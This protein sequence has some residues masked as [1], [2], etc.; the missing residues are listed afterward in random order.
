ML[1]GFSYKILCKLRLMESYTGAPFA[2]F[3]GHDMFMSIISAC[4]REIITLEKDLSPADSILG[5]SGLHISQRGLDICEEAK[6]RPKH[7]DMW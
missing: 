3:S 7:G 5:T 2:R 1:N 4:V 6:G